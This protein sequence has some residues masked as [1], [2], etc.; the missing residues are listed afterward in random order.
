MPTHLRTELVLDA[1]N[2]A[3]WQR[4][5]QGLIYHSDPGLAVQVDRLRAP[6]SGGPRAAVDGLGQRCLRQRALRELR[7]GPRVRA[8]RPAALP[9]P[10]RGP[11]GRLRVPRGL[12]QSAP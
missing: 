1:L 5:S 10:G 9:D 11:P 7:R 2:M 8:P 6:L 4:R 3:L 12:V